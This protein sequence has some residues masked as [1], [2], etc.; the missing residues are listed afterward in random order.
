MGLTSI[1]SVTSIPATPSTQAAIPAAAGGSLNRAISA[2]VG[3]LNEAGYA[4]E[5]REVTFSID[6]STRKTVIKVID[7]STKE[8]ITQWP[9]EYLLQLAA[10]RTNTR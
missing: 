3:K 4:G 1:D 5:G 9:P 8:V 10:E 2:A 7:T 6:Q